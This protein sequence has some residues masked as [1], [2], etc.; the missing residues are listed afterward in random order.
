MCCRFLGSSRTD[1][2]VEVA[3]REEDGRVLVVGGRADGV[4]HEGAQ[5]LRQQLLLGCVGA[6]WVP[7][8]DRRTP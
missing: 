8:D 1:R 7:E 6:V 2:G 5:H 4:L 3:L